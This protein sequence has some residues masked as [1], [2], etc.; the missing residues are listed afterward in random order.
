MTKNVNFKWTQDDGRI[1]LGVPEE[2]ETKEGNYRD[3]GCSLHFTTSKFSIG[4]KEKFEL[5]L[6]AEDIN[7]LTTAIWSSYLKTEP[8]RAKKDFKMICELIN[9]KIVEM[10]DC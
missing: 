8:S 5:Y 3:G 7:R 6:Y 4:I 9:K 10:E 1:E 2:L